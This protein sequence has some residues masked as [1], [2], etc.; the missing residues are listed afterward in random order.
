MHRREF[1]LGILGYPPPA[2]YPQVCSP[3]RSTTQLTLR[4][5]PSPNST[6]TQ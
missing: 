5:P 2:F 1:N 6:N 3:N 4:R